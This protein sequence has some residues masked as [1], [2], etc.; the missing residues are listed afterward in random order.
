LYGFEGR[1][2]SMLNAQEAFEIAEANDQVKVE[3]E[4]ID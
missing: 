2:V 3:L 1:G 4:K